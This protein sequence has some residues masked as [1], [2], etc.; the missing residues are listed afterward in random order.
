MIISIIFMILAAIAVFMRLYARLFVLKNS[1]L[2]ELA[3][4]ASF[5]CLTTLPPLAST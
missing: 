1:G 2:D 4:S 5:V 3:I